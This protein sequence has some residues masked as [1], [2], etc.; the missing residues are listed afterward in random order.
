[1]L[2]EK[3][4]HQVVLPIYPY[5]AEAAR[6]HAVERTRLMGLGKTPPFVDGEIAS[7]AATQNLTLVTFNTTDFAQFEGLTLVDWR[8]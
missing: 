5:D 4:L 2:I 3:Y 7:I 6:W 1:M 8:K